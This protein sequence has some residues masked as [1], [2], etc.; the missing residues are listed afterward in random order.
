MNGGA[1]AGAAEELAAGAVSLRASL[2]PSVTFASQQNDIAVLTDLVVRNGADHDL[3]DLVVSVSAE[4]PVFGPRSWAFD[5]IAA[6]DEARP[7]DRHLPLSGGFLDKLTD[8]VRAEVRFELRQG[9]VL[10]A[11]TVQPLTA[12]ARHEWGGSAYVPELLA[13]FVTPNDPAVDRLLKAASEVMRAAGKPGALDGYQSG[14]RTRAWEVM[15]AIWSAVAARGLSYAVPPASFE[16]TGQK[17]RLPTDVE[18]TG[19]AT[20]LDTAL[21]FTAA[22]EQ[23]GLH[24]MVVF[25]R[26][27]AFAGAWLQPQ[28]LPSMTTDDPQVLRKALALNEL[29]LFE[30]T[31]A[32]ADHPVAFSKAIAE[33]A[34]QLAE[35][36]DAD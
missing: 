34:R 10:L 12:L 6:G 11:E 1:L 17:V 22:F 7:R 2:A 27:H 36:R 21:L 19:L 16:T 8:R 20:C 23:A 24:P 28:H 33:A 18:A 14:S 32:T 4:P 29:V 31:L 15:A 35:E 13:A 5:R 9:G 30:T 26:G 3:E 25:T